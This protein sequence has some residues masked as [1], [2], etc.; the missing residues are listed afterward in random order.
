MQSYLL[1]DEKKTHLTFERNEDALIVSIPTK[2]PDK[3]NSVVVLDV[4]GKVDVNNPPTF[5]SIEKIFIDSLDVKVK[6]DRENVEIRYTING[7]IPTI[8][9][10]LANEKVTLT[11]TTVLTA[12]CFRDGNPVSGSVQKTFTKVEPEHALKINDVIKGIKYRYFEGN[13]EVLPA[14]N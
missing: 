10:P 7:N 14:F 11:T 5:E 3:N 1:S 12:R 8:E 4:A 6:S 9:S 13:W 2:T